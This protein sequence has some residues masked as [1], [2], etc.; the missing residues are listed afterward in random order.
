MDRKKIEQ[1][2]R[3]ILEGLG[4]D[5]TREG[6]AKT[7]ERVA[8]MCEEIFEGI[9]KE[10]ELKVGFTE[11][12]GAG[13]VIKLKDID[14]Y[15]VCE[16]HLLPF[17]GKVEIIYAPKDNLVAGFSDFAKIV[18]EVRWE[19]NLAGQEHVKI[20]VSGGLTEETI[21][22]L[23]PLVD[24]FGVGTVISN[25]PVVDFSMD[26]VE[27]EG[28]PFSKRGMKSGAKQVFRCSGCGRDKVLPLDGEPE[29]CAC[30]GEWKT[31]LGPLS[32]D[33]TQPQDVRARVLE[34]LAGFPKN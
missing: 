6:L 9:G 5:V 32:G 4:E 7:P 15:S 2:V 17:F 11:D 31:L 27:V 8:K 24:G 13:T 25:A 26:I 19:L 23:A 22:E 1:G 33:K 10:P 16:H 30:G 20:L 21:Q 34:Q 3:L 29:A 12:V 28:R 14:F 18:E